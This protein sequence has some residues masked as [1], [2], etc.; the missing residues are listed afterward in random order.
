L[1]CVTHASSGRLFPWLLRVVM[2]CLPVVVSTLAFGLCTHAPLVSLAV[3][4]GS[5]RW[6]YCHGE[7][8]GEKSAGGDVVLVVEGSAT[9]LC[10]PALA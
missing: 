2:V 8:W 3:S 9:G 10:Q 7:P 4:L 6:L 1:S 5:T